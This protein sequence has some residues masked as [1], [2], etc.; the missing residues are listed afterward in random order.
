MARSET[1]CTLLLALK[2]RGLQATI[3]NVAIAIENCT[4][5]EL[6]ERLLALRHLPLD[7]LEEL[8]RNDRT[9]FIDKFDYYFIPYHQRL[10]YASYYLTAS[11]WV[12][13]LND[14]IDRLQRP[15][16]SSVILARYPERDAHVPTGFLNVDERSAELPEPPRDASAGLFGFGLLALWRHAE[17]S[18]RG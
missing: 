6:K 11:G 8:V 1:S 2:Q 5:V 14:L 16:R 7:E 10:N 9:P 12:E 17:R 13:L 18:V 3:S 15:R 4:P